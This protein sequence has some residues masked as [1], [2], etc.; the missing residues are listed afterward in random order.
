MDDAE[1]LAHYAAD[2]LARRLLADLDGDDAPSDDARRLRD[3]LTR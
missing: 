3:A 1:L 2:R